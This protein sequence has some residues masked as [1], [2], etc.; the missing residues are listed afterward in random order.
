MIGHISIAQGMLREKVQ[1]A[2]AVSG[3]AAGAGGAYDPEPSWEV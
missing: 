3:E 2:G 1:D